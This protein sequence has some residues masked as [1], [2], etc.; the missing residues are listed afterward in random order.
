MRIRSALPSPLTS[1]RWSCR[2]GF[3]PPTSLSP[4]I[5]GN[6]EPSDRLTWAYALPLGCCQIR[7]R[8]ALPSPLTSAKYS[9]LD[10]AQPPTLP[11]A[12]G[13]GNP[14]PSDRLTW[15][16]ASPLGCCQIRIR[17]A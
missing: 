17:S 2:L 5:V 6:P 11:L 1:A 12:D 13:D 9:L 7:I 16:Y 15:A 10:A 4:V 8:S 3:Q 14:E